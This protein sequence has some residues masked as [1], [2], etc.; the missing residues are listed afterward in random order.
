MGNKIYLLIYLFLYFFICLFIVS[1][2]V[3]AIYTSDVTVSASIGG[4]STFTLFGY[5]SPDST[6]TLSSQGLYDEGRSD[7]AGYFIFKDKPTSLYKQELCFT[8]QDQ[9]G[10]ISTPICIPA[11][12]AETIDRIGPVILP[13]TVSLNNG[14]IFIGEEPI[15]SG[16]TIPNTNVKL[17]LFTDES[18]NRRNIAFKAFVSP[19]EAYTIPNLHISSDS[20]GNYSIAL[21]STQSK[22]Y[23]MFTQS[24]YQESLS[25]KSNTL[26]LDVM[27]FWMYLI[28]LLGFLWRS[29][30]NYLFDFIIVSQIISLGVFFLRKFL[31]PYHLFRFYK[32]RRSYPLALR[33][34]QTLVVENNPL[35][36]RPS[37][38]IEVENN[39]LMS[40]I[41]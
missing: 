30:R 23:R 5:T 9:L 19:V 40:I 26:H 24:L 29:F 25:P 34:I 36:F 39:P 10:R 3:S 38:A 37:H 7:N 8:T 6:V 31:Q 27:P 16:Q 21:S 12:P 14:N 35:A 17:S 22:Y 18:V 2:P 11:L 15:L 33:Q 32:R 28:Q 1:S 20:Q 4:G 41:R 13:P